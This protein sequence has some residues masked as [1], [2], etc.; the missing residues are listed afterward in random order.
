VLGVVV[1]DVGWA[2][3]EVVAGGYAGDTAVAVED[4]AFVESVVTG[5]VLGSEDAER[6]RSP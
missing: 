3:D 4:S 6:G 1:D 5:A 2:G